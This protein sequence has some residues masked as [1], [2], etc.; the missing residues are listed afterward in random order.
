MR[1]VIAR[2][3]R[4]RDPFRRPDLPP[5]RGRHAL[6]P[7]R[8]ARR[9]RAGAARRLGRPP[10]HARA[11]AR[12]WRP[13]WRRHFRHR[14]LFIGPNARQGRQRG[15]R[16][17]RARVPVRRA[18]AVL[19]GRPAARRGVRQRHA[20]RRARVLLAGDV[21]RGDARGDRG[22]EDRHRPVQRGDARGRSASRSSTSSQIDLAIEV[23]E[24]PVRVPAPVDRRRRA[25][26]RRVHRGPRAGRRHAPAGDR[27][28]P[29][30]DR[31]APHGQ[32][33]PRHPH[34][35]VHGRRRRPRRGGR[36]HRAP[37]GAQ[38]G[39][40]RDRVHDGHDEAVPTSS[41]T[42]RWS[43]CGPSTSPTTPTSSGRSGT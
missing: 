33:G 36:R 43:R 9:P 14:A 12:T 20:A 8:R 4:R 35:D 15:P 1:I 19:V 41:T 16:G 23:D 42:T 27:R 13:R 6:G 37:Q 10:P 17:L 30:G 21:G 18:G 24:P 11:R 34:R 3:S 5:V 28:D 39:Q 40:D 29:G 2:R 38:P 25:A 32:E 22:R 31:A 7:A 26:D